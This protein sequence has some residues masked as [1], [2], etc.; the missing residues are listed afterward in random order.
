MKEN[1]LLSDGG[2][3]Q[4]VNCSAM[5]AL[6]MTYTLLRTSRTFGS[7][8]LRSKSWPRSTVFSRL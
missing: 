4:G 6:G 7:S 5:R 2:G 1:G 3:G 8:S